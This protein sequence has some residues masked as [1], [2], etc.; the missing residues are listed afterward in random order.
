MKTIALSDFELNLI[1]GL[2][3]DEEIRLKKTYKIISGYEDK[4]KKNKKIYRR[5]K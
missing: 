4:F 1:H 3:A 5:S 2:L